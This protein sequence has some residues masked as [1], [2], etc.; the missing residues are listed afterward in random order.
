GRA[1][2]LAERE[3]AHADVALQPVVAGAQADA[4]AGDR[5]AQRADQI[6]VVEP[7]Q[8]GQQ[9]AHGLRHVDADRRER[10]HA[11]DEQAPHPLLLARAGGGGLAASGAAGRGRRSRYGLPRS[12]A[13]RRPG[14]SGPTK[15]WR[16]AATLR[17]GAHTARAIS[18]TRAW[19]SSTTMVS[20]RARR[21]SMRSR[22]TNMIGT[23]SS[24]SANL[25]GPA[26][27]SPSR[28][29]SSPGW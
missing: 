21:S 1:L 18:D 5:L 19:S 27:V 12:S 13:R 2:A 29:T 7:L 22:V 11:G 8:P 25:P 14:V 20:T 17:P 15:I 16:R 28:R 24:G 4:R 3:A 23:D 6:Q 26:R 9:R 10:A